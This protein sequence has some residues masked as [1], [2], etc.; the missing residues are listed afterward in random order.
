MYSRS[1]RADRA[2][3][4]TTVSDAASQHFLDVAETAANT[5]SIFVVAALGV[6]LLNSPPRS[7]N[8]VYVQAP[9]ERVGYPG[10][11]TAS[12]APW[13]EMWEQPEAYEDADP[14]TGT[15]APDFERDV[16]FSLE[17]DIS[18]KAKLRRWNP[19]VVLHSSDFD[20]DDA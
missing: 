9:V 16:L 3:D 4:T 13:P 5:A 11:T 17:V 2:T 15:F 7:K 1:V 10:D 8:F 6:Q 19:E 14:I 18:P 12:T 20:P